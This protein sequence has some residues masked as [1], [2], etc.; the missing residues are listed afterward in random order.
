MHSI[1]LRDPNIASS[2]LCQGLWLQRARP[3]SA[4]TVR[5][6]LEW[7]LEVASEGHPLPP[8][9]FVAD[10]GQLNLAADWESRPG[11]GTPAPPNWPAGL[12][13][14]YEDH[15]LGKF[16]ADLSVVR[17]TDALRRYQ[18][19]RDQ[20]RGLA[21]LIEQFREYA[22]VGG[23]L[24]S[25]GIIK[26]LLEADPQETLTRG[27]RSLDRDGPQPLLIELYESLVWAVRLIAEILR[28]EDVFELEHGTALQ[29]LGERVAL[30]Q[31]LQAAAHL[32]AA[33][34]ARR[35]RTLPHRQDVAT[36]ILDDDT[37]P[38]GG[39]ASLSTRGS[40]ESLLQSQLAYM[41]KADRPDLFDAKYLRDE[42]L[43]YSRDEN[44]F[45]RRRRTF[46]FVLFSDL[47]QTRF[48]DAGLPWQRGVLLLAMLVIAVRKLCD[49]LS[50]DALAFVF[51][52]P[53]RLGPEC[54]LLEIVLR[55]Q[56]ANKTVEI[57]SYTESGQVEEHCA[58]RARRSL[59]HCAAISIAGNTLTPDDTMSLQI[60]MNRPCPK[61]RPTLAEQ[62]REESEDLLFAWSAALDS[63]LQRWL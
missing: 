7:A 34:P 59:C 10:V 44:Q 20:A 9:G 32:E 5:P 6:A 22:G 42:L 56:V 23:V 27:W 41:E 30:R 13:R 36:R 50:S 51:Y 19:G 14:S 26:S 45:L 60:Q 24:L 4:A 28:P 35:P 12:L 37:Y 17:A 21:F 39:F 61:I 31:V 16:Y 33:L 57:E 55:E 48:K 40:V 2:F 62:D 54:E 46:A 38:V 29:E 3:V 52:V 63:L 1:E 58:R 25:P 49:W 18:A 15:V 8:I 53:D 47:V 11:R 43:Y